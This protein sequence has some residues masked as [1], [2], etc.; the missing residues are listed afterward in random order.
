MK[1]LF[2]FTW[3]SRTEIAQDVTTEFD[4]HIDERIRALVESGM[5]PAEAHAQ[6]LRE[7]GNIAAGA[8]GCAAID[9][10]SE[11]RRRVGR[12]LADLGQDLRYGMRLVRR[13][14]GF[15]LAAILTLGVAI[16]G[17]TAVFS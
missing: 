4:F 2:R 3:R 8:R 16:G 9:A 10:R 15:A 1:R 6:A 11:T 12:T 7:F 17:N 13:N 14:P 5:P